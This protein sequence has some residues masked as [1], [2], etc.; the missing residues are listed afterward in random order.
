MRH[1]IYIYAKLRASFEVYTELYYIHPVHVK[2]S[3]RTC[4]LQKKLMTH[5][6]NKTANRKEDEKFTT[7]IKLMQISAKTGFICPCLY[8]NA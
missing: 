5:W 7:V 8:Y 3:L 6:Y 4:A 2:L 1:V